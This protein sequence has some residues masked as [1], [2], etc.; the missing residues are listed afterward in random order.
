MK[1]SNLICSSFL[2]IWLHILQ[3]KT[4]NRSIQILGI[5]S[6]L[7]GLRTPGDEVA[8]TARPKINYHSQTFRY[9]R[10]I[11]CLPHWPKFSGFFDL[12]PHWVSVV[13]GFLHQ[14]F[15]LILFTY[16]KADFSLFFGPFYY[17]IHI[18]QFHVV[19]FKGPTCYP[20]IEKYKGKKS[21]CS[22]DSKSLTWY[23]L[24]KEEKLYAS[25]R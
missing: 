3:K 21:K 6:F 17:A 1:L 20:F 8:F 24:S 7:H 4:R 11:F 5:N 12:C 10:S 15:R 25:K 13:C 22:F 2:R 19:N 18:H 23:W 9:G 14:K 16:L